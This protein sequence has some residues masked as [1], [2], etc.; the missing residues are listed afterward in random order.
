MEIPETKVLEGKLDQ[1]VK[2]EPKVNKAMAKLNMITS[3]PSPQAMKANE[4]ET[5]SLMKSIDQA[6]NGAH[7]IESLDVASTAQEKGKVG[8]NEEPDPSE[9][10]NIK[11]VKQAI[12]KVK[13]SVDNKDTK[14]TTLALKD[15]I[16][17]A[18]A[19]TG[20]W[21]QAPNRVL[22]NGGNFISKDVTTSKPT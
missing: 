13:T 18:D 16:S 3:M 6:T 22:P 4:A 14:A 19:Y 21:A 10:S 12:E 8:A 7:A 11:S 15:A 1:M 20:E 2:L 9:A 17:K 5:G